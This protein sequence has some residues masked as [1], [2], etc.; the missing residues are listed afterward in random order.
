MEEKKGK[1]SDFSGFLG[2]KFNYFKGLS[3]V[4]KIIEC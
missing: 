4:G 3:L 2:R 1:M